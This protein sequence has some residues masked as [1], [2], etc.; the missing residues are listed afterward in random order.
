MDVRDREER[1]GHFK[2]Q[3]RILERQDVSGKHRIRRLKLLFAWFD[4][5][6]AVSGIFRVHPIPVLIIRVCLDVLRL[7]NERSCITLASRGKTI[8]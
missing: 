4:R 6:S 1:L 2:R 7:E 3:S 8:K 5:L